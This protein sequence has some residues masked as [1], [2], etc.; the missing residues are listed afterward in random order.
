MQIIQPYAA[1]VIKSE[2]LVL[3]GSPSPSSKHFLHAF[4]LKRFFLQERQRRSCWRPGGDIILC[5]IQA[6]QV[7]TK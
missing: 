6:V 2:P 3:N 1:P 5:K 4:L 7:K